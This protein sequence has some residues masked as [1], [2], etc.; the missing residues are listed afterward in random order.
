MSDFLDSL[1]NAASDVVSSIVDNATI[2]KKP[3]FEDLNAGQRVFGTAGKDGF[4]QYNLPKLKYSFI[5]EFVLSEFAKNFI[6]TQLI[7]THGSFNVRNVSCFVKEVKLPT[8]SFELEEMNQYNK[9]RFSTGKI[10]YKPVQMSFYDTVDSSAL[11]LIDAYKKYYYGDFFFKNKSSFTN[12]VL[13]SPSQ[14]ESL[15]PNW[16]RSVMNN[17]D[18]DSQY[19]FKQIN[20]YEIDN[21][22]YTVHNMFNAYIEDFEMSTKSHESSGD[23]ST[24]DLTL[25]YEG[26]GNYNPQGY[27]SIA[28]P[29]IEIGKLITDTTLYG[30][31]GFFKYYGAMDDT[32]IGL[33]TVGKVI[34][35]GTAG[36]DIVES[37]GD[38][39]SGNVSAETIR[40]IGAAIS[41][42]SDAIGLGDIVS[43]ANNKFGLGNILGDF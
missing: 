29:S 10:N 35:A 34:R 18:Y 1:G 15:A 14:F 3:Q 39:L 43:S 8:Q 12:D 5:V 13:S 6:S 22:T 9:T 2:V 40:N 30:Q 11:L 20:V 23:P 42:G 36:Y 4:T 26:S 19:F 32:T 41:K 24:L 28:S 27:A 17:G 33:G 7:D 16:G 37:I 21:D 31:S 38:I 25:R